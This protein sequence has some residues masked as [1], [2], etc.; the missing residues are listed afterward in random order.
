MRLKPTKLI[1]NPYNKKEIEAL[2]KKSDD[3]YRNLYS[4]D[5]NPNYNLLS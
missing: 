4:E 1:N 2:K 3:F 5:N